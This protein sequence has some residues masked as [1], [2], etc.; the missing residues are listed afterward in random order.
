M[1]LIP[2]EA[3]EKIKELLRQDGDVLELVET[4]SSFTG[5][6]YSVK[7]RNSAYLEAENIALNLS[8]KFKRD[9]EDALQDFKLNWNNTRNTFRIVNKES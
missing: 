1:L 3:K 8:D 4:E 5:Y 6:R 7:L 9:I 2:P